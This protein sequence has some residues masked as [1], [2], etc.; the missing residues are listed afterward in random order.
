MHVLERTLRSALSSARRATLQGTARRPP[1]VNHLTS[2]SAVS[3]GSFSSS[4]RVGVFSPSGRAFSQATKPLPELHKPKLRGKKKAKASPKKLTMQKQYLDRL[5]VNPGDAD[6]A[7]EVL[8]A[9]NSA[10]G[11]GLSREV[12]NA[13]VLALAG[14]NKMQRA[15][16]VLELAVKQKLPLKVPPFERVMTNCYKQTDFDAALKVF[17]LLRSKLTPSNLMSTTALLAAHRSGKKELVLELLGQMLKCATPHEASALQVA[18]SAAV[19]SKEHELVL[20]LVDCSKTLGIQLTSEHYHI[21]L[22]SYA[23]TG[24]MQAALGTRDTLQQHGFK[25][26]DD[27]VYWLVYCAGKADQWDVVQ[28]LLGSPSP[29]A[30]KEGVATASAFNAAIAA[31]GNQGRWAKVADVYGLMPENL[32]SQLKGWHLGAVI[33]AHAR[34]ETKEEKLRALEIFNE[35]KEKASDFAYGGAITALL[36]TEQFDAALAFAEDMKAKDIAWGKS[37]YQA[38]AL[39]LIRRGTAEEAVQLLEASVQRMGDGPA[40]YMDII[41]FYTDRHTQA[42]TPDEV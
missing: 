20:Q 14:E 30:D 8:T 11:S 10:N 37:V 32:C 17:D 15:F 41:Q 28:R 6:V 5:Q 3:C 4:A 25:L 19:K 12:A 31:F 42:A 16:Q 40:G 9:I 33:M 2:C 23:A 22:R 24:H 35:H 13:L 27:G 18:L 34:A 29:S 7:L 36:E 21:L 26:T 39:A 38:V 1:L